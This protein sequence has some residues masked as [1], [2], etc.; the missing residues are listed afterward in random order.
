[1][2]DVQVTLAQ[3]GPTARRVAAIGHALFGGLYADVVWRESDRHSRLVP[4]DG[5]GNARLP[6]RRVID[7]GEPIWIE[8]FDD[9]PLVREFGLIRGR[10]EVRCFLAVP[11]TSGD[12]VLGALGA[13]GDAPRARDEAMLARFEDL[14]TLI[15]EAFEAESTNRKLQRATA[16]LQGALAESKRSEKRLEVATRLAGLRVWELNNDLQ[17][18]FENGSTMQLGD[19]YAEKI[20]AIWEFLHPD[21]RAGARAMWQAHLDHGLPFHRV[22]RRMGPN[23]FQWIEAAVEA[24]RDADGRV[25]GAVGAARDIEEEKRREAELI[26]ARN[27]AEAANASKSAFLATISHEIRTPL[28]GILGMAQA[29][30]RDELPDVQRE[31]LDVIR[32]SGETLLAVVNDVLDLSKIGAGKLELEDVEFD[33]AA[34]ITSAHATFAPVAAEKGLA[35]DLEVGACAR[36]VYRGDPVRVRQILYNLISNALKFT[37]AGEVRVRLSRSDAV[38]TLEVS[39]TG[40]GIPIERQKALFQPFVQA[41]ASTTRRYGG[42]GLGL[43]ICRELAMLMDGIITVTSAPGMGSTFTVR[44][45]LPFVRQEAG[46][47]E[48]AQ[49]EHSAE[50]GLGALRVLAAEDNPVNQMVLRTLLEQVG[51]KLKIVENGREAVD[52]WAGGEW[53]LILMDAQMPEMDGVEAASAIRA[54][55]AA[56]GR[57]RTPIIALTANAM[58]HQVDAYRDC[59]M[60]A[61]VPKPVEVARLFAAMRDVLD[62]DAA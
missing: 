27:A 55:E 61:T 17:Q 5:D 46:G 56:Q 54:A 16:E 20:D 24:V 14:A 18:A 26:E 41:D 34:A 2:P 59:G 48:A 28:N 42:S 36:G 39:D 32:Q 4:F 29:M 7:T 53:D 10:P 40:V 23:G 49:P 13:I 31:R 45:P 9:N 33:L 15:G 21:D 62:T 22:H 60:D 43:S 44:L 51:V 37:E 58:A 38:L 6:S 12:L 52:A 35:F 1:M 19:D 50:D 57:Q 30:H 8:D 25:C 11:I 3:I 47:V